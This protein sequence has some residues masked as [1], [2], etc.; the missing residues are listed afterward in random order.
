[1]AS[2][3][4]IADFLTKVRNAS[5][6]RHETVEVRASRMAERILEVLKHEGFIRAYKQVGERPTTRVLRIYL[7]YQHKTPVLTH[8]VRV[9]KPGQRRYRK[10]TNLPRVLKGLGTAIVSTSQGVM[11]ERE[12]YRQRIGGEVLC[13]A[14]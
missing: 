5:A 7:K 10:A 6:A 2:S 13:Y 3:D 8:L 12:A 11:T 14:W 9:S 4:P 1:M